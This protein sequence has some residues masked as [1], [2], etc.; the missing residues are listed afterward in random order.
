MKCQYGVRPFY[1]NV[2]LME[3]KEHYSVMHEEHTGTQHIVRLTLLI[4]HLE[5]LDNSFPT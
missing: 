5:T 4:S 3:K 2:Q 1:C